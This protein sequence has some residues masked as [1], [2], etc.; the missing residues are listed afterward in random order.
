[1]MDVVRAALED[2]DVLLYLDDCT[3]PLTEED[4]HAVSVL[5]RITSPSFL[6]LNKID[7]LEDKRLLLPR[8]EK[9]KAKHEFL[10]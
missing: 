8:I 3:R 10:A 4:E 7:R 5:D 1:M 2:R 9:Y 6:V